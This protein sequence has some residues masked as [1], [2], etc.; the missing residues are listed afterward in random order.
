MFCA[1]L[2]R[3]QA[4]GGRGARCARSPHVWGQ[5]GPSPAGCV[6]PPPPVG[7]PAAPTGPGIW[8]RGQQAV[9]GH[10]L[11]SRTHGGASSRPQVLQGN[12]AGPLAARPTVTHGNGGGKL[13][14]EGL[15]NP[16]VTQLVARSPG[17]GPSLSPR[18]SLAGWVTGRRW[19]PAEPGWGEWTPTPQQGLQVRGSG[20]WHL[21]FTDGP[22]RLLC[23]WCSV[24][25]H[26]V[27]GR[28]V[29]RSFRCLGH[30]GSCLVTLR[31]TPVFPEGTSTS[32]KPI[33]VSRPFPPPRAL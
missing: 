1:R 30:Q 25:V 7:A 3:Q 5:P 2:G 13:R 32:L 16:K 20:A 24:D 6:G 9:S 26:P 17:H 15:P 28:P 4:V 11:I 31:G 8:S 10:L 27:S 12:P 18:T 33:F 22:G 29:L 23:S 14:G 21:L 19:G